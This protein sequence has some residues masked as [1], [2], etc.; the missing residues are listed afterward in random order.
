MECAYNIGDRSV[1]QLG[2]YHVQL[3]NINLINTVDNY[4]FCY[5]VSK[6]LT[7]INRMW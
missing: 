6:S 1:L 7:H 2:D 3:C 4:A 5:V